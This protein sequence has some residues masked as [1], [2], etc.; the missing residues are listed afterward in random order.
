MSP[1]SLR[2]STVAMAAIRDCVDPRVAP[3]PDAA[4]LRA[5]LAQRYGLDEAGIRVGAG[6]AALLHAI[7]A[8]HAVAGGRLLVSQGSWPPYS[9]IAAAYRLRAKVVSLRDYHHDLVAMVTA[10]GTRPA[11]VMLDS[12]HWATGAVVALPQV[13]ALARAL[14][15]GSVVVVDNAYGEYQ[16]DDPASG[17]RDTVTVGDGQVL[18]SRTFSKAHQ[19]FGLRVGYLLAAPH[20]MREHGP[21]VGRYDVSRIGHDAALASL[22]DPSHL[23]GNQ[24]IVRS[25][26]AAATAVLNESAIPH[27]RS[28]GHGVLFAPPQ[29]QT[30][31][32]KLRAAGATVLDA[33]QHGLQGHLNLRV[34]DPDGDVCA[35]LRTALEA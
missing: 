4:P 33:R 14:P 19:L 25:R 6:S 29:P 3:E 5:A 1:A 26:R 24:H 35:A 21:L 8:R 16:D 9:Q 18:I 32:D 22:S 2:P 28:Q 13:R 10:A 34:D 31:A 11:L 20:V 30:V 15:P 27:A 17:L 23:A 7:I 12:P